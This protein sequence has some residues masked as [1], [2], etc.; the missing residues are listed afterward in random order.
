MFQF[1]IPSFD[2]L[3]FFLVPLW[4]Q[5]I[6]Q[7]GL[8]HQFFFKIEQINTNWG[9]EGLLLDIVKK[10][11]QEGLQWFDTFLWAI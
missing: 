6:Y 5:L 8:A 7:V 9:L 11:M 10:R 1:I 3:F 4:H 2:L